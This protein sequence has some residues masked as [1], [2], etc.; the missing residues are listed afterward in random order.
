MFDARAEFGRAAKIAAQANRLQT[1]DFQRR[2]M[3]YDPAA[4][5]LFI[6]GLLA[7]FT[8][9]F[10][11]RT[12]G[13]GLETERPVLVIGL[14]R[15]GTTLVEQILASHSRVFGSGGPAART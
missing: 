4:H 2:G 14:A 6:D 1:A 3:A 13:W 11:A 8:P 7:A 9:E 10:F 5:K 15:S 12:H